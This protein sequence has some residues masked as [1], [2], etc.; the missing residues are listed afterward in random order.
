MSEQ[1][2]LHGALRSSA[3]YRV[4][5][6]L[7]LKGLPFREIFLDLAKGEHHA[8]DYRAI[9]PQGLAPALV[10]PEGAVIS[11][12]LAILD[13]IEEMHPTPP[14]LPADP[15]GRARVR[16]LA[17]IIACDLHPINNMR[18]R[19]HIRDLFP[20]DSHAQARWMT[21]WSKAGF[22]ALEQR[23]SEEPQTGS[24]CHGENP[25]YADACLVPQVFNATLTGF[26]LAPYPRVRAIADACGKLPGFRA[27]HP[28]TMQR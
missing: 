5:I 10:C 4:R 14:I 11:Q 8:A 9:N 6:G 18:V 24:F 27:A 21:K 22:D 23:L 17:Q 19:N 13:Y 3:T 15:A 1:Y 7:H 16:S 12:S 28:D 25:G 20:D 26:D 2:T